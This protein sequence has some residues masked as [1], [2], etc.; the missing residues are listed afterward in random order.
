MTPE[1]RPL[2]FWPGSAAAVTA[3]AGPMP[4]IA[5]PGVTWVGSS[6]VKGRACCEGEP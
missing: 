3:A 1:R 4:E 2:I 6:R 5:E